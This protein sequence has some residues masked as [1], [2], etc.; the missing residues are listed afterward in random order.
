MKSHSMKPTI[1]RKV[2]FRL[3]GA[4]IETPAGTIQI[5]VFDP[6]QALDATVV[7]VHDEPKVS[8]NLFVVDHGGFTHSFRSVPLRQDGEEVPAGMYCEWMPYQTDSFIEAIPCFVD[9]V[10]TLEA[11]I[12]SKG[13]TAPRVTP[14]HIAALML[15]VQFTFHSEATSTFCHAFLDGEFFLA[16][17][18][19]ACVSKKNFNAETGKKIAK[20]TVL[21]PASDKLWELEGYA[22]RNALMQV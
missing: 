5:Q 6:E 14:A 1:G 2:W 11:E 12:V 3:N 15:R 7:L 8:V 13:L 9:E 21:K 19:S 10:K 18:H 4:T 22:L 17:G 16:T 20:L